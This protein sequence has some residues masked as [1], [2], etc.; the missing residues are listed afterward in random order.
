[1]AKTEDQ[2]EGALV[3]RKHKLGQ[4]PLV[5]LHQS[6]S[7]M[8]TELLTKHAE[9]GDILDLSQIEQQSKGG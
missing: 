4:W 7:I 8:S 6:E 3:P 5:T 9:K 1:M 2:A